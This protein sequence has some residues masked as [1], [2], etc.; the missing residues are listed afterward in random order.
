MSACGKP[1]PGT[2]C[3]PMSQERWS[4]RGSRTWVEAEEF[5]LAPCLFFAS[6]GI[7]SLSGNSVV[8]GFP[9]AMSYRGLGFFAPFSFKMRLF[10]LSVHTF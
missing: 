10:L 1:V 3:L 4:G 2:P 9:Y 7:D 6:C 8:N 5:R